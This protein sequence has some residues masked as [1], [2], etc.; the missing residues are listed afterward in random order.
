MDT[1]KWEQQQFKILITNIAGYKLYPIT[2][3]LIN[4]R[5][6]MQKL[7]IG[8]GYTPQYRDNPHIWRGFRAVQEKSK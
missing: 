1:A 3:R 2:Q 6:T 4:D 5:Q 8:K 7:C